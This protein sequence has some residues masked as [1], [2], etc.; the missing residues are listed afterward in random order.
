MYALLDTT[1]P[2]SWYIFQNFQNFKIKK[3]WSLKTEKTGLHV[4]GW[5]GGSSGW[6]VAAA[7]HLGNSTVVGV[8]DERWRPRGTSWDLVACT[9]NR[10]SPCLGLR[11][12]SRSMQCRSSSARSVISL[13]F[14]M[15]CFG[16]RESMLPV[17]EISFKRSQKM[18][19][20]CEQKS[21]RIHLD[22]ICA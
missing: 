18:S 17:F 6:A 20:N 12:G 21:W 22:I 13:I 9:R 10:S 4:V 3:I 19:K 5:G 7:Y 15:R 2:M 16:T 11:C 1:L 14:F 8:A